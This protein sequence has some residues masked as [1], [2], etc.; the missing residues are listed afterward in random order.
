MPSVRLRTLSAA[1]AVGLAMATIATAACSQ[2]PAAPAPAASVKACNYLVSPTTVGVGLNGGTFMVSVNAD[3]GSTC[4]WTAST[5]DE[6]IHVAG[7]TTGQGTGALQLTISTP[8]PLRRHGTVAVSWDGGAASISVDQ[9]CALPATQTVNLNAESQIYLTSNPCTFNGRAIEIDVPWLHFIST[10]GGG[11]QIGVSVALN[12]GPERT[13][14]ITTAIGVITIV[15]APGN[16]VTALT[17]ASQAFDANGGSGSFT[18]TALPG[19][20][21]EATPH[22]NGSYKLPWSHGSGNGEVTFTMPLN[23][24]PDILSWYYIVGGTSR[25][26]ITESGCGGLTVSPLNLRVPAALGDFS[27][28]VTGGSLCAWS[29]ASNDAFIMRPREDRTGPGTV[30]FRVGLNDT[31]KIRSGSLSVARQTVTVTQDP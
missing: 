31:G 18:V 25:F 5:A 10:Y 4:A 19:C 24:G 14:H 28:A 27:V 26:E 6:W 15:Q 20:P 8:S 17:P 7:P 11:F 12:T 29:D 23:R 21:W 16:C 13:G 22:D 30:E 1:E 3:A 2:S 9:G